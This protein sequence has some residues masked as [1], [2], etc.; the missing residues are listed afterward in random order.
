MKIRGYVSV[1]NGIAKTL[2]FCVCCGRQKTGSKAQSF[3]F[4]I[5]LVLNCLSPANCTKKLI[6]S[7]WKAEPQPYLEHQY[8]IHALK[9]TE[10]SE[11]FHSQ[12]Q[13]GVEVFHA[14]KEIQARII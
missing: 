2:V 9:A 8:E 10:A 7:S 13:S 11:C 4:P 6:K 5:P 14:N 3:W 12:Q 1:K